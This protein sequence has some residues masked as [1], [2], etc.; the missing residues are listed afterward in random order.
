MSDTLAV[1]ASLR[2]LLQAKSFSKGSEK[3]AT[4]LPIVKPACDFSSFVSLLWGQ[5]IRSGAGSIVNRGTTLVG[6][7][8][9]RPILVVFLR[10]F[11]SKIAALISFKVELFHAPAGR[12]AARYSRFT[13]AL[14]STAV[15]VSLAASLTLSTL[16]VH[17]TNTNGRIASSAFPCIYR[18]FRERTPR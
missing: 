16:R 15:L 4:T 18:L 11:S 10:L 6:L 1:S 2:C 7:V 13:T 14:C 5:W 8:A 9:V 12:C 17:A 3:S